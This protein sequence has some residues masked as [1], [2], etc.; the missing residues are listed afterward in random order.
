M[1]LFKRSK[2]MGYLGTILFYFSS[3]LRFRHLEFLGIFNLLY[4]D[5]NFCLVSNFHRSLGDWGA[6]I[7]IW[8][9]PGERAAGGQGQAPHSGGEQALVSKEQEKGKREV[10]TDVLSPPS[11]FLIS[12]GAKVEAPPVSAWYPTLGGSLPD[13]TGH[14]RIEQ[15]QRLAFQTDSLQKGAESSLL[16]HKR[17]F[18]AGVCSWSPGLRLRGWWQ[19]RGS[20]AK[21]SGCKEP[22]SDPF[23]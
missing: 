11:E 8:G 19:E 10:E 4:G 3:F 2:S 5:H 16:T 9:K 15:F 12:L 6:E 22:C 18:G 7:R 13:P 23:L 21:P 1:F 20:T 14:C 17:S